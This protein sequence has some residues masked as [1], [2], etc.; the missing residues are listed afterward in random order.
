MI[1]FISGLIGIFGDFISWSFTTYITSGISV[2]AMILGM[3]I[4]GLVGLYFLHRLK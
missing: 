1:D 3:N 4:M 2:G